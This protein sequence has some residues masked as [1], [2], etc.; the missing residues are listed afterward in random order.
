MTA[1]EWMNIKISH[2][3]VFVI[4]GPTASGKTTLAIELAEKL[5]TEIVSADSRQCY[6]EMRIGVARPTT[7]ELSQIPHHFIASHSIHD[8]LSAGW[9]E[10]YA[11]QVAQD[12]LQRTGFAIVVGGTG[13]YLKALIHGLDAIPPID[14]SVRK[15]IQDAFQQ[16]GLNWL[17]QECLKADPKGY[18]QVDHQNPSRLIRLL[19]FFRCHGQPLS[20][21]Q[22]ADKKHRPFPM[23]CYYLNPDRPELYHRINQRVEAMLDAG[24]ESEARALYPFKNLPSLQT[25]GYSEFFRY[26]DAEL[27]L[28]TCIHLIKQHTRNYAKRQLTWFRHQEMFNPIQS[29]RDLG[30]I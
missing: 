26:F 5:Q 15:T 13:L 17:Q 4:G 6:R 28:S 20:Q 22:T 16:L 21:F 11:L 1:R 25:V 23:R 30:P 8:T 9:Y 24:L 19:E 12:I 7:E 14:A 3:T 2:G 18:Q 10:T 27:D 29:L